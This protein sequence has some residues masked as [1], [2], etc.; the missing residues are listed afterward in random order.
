MGPVKRT[1]TE[2][3]AKGILEQLKIMNLEDEK[4]Y[5]LYGFQIS[6]SESDPAA[7]ITYLEDAIGMTPAYMDYT[8]SVFNYGSWDGAFFMPRPCMV[9]YDGTVDYY[10]NVNDFTKKE[11]GTA[12]DISDA[13]Y[14]GNAMIEWGRNGKK[15]WY[16]ADAANN[17]VYICDK[18]LDEDFHAWS[19]INS[20]GDYVD[21]FYTP[22]F[23][24][25]L[26]ANNKMRSLSGK[27]LSKSLTAYKEI[28]YCEN[29][30]PSTD[31]LWYIDVFA[32]RILINILL[33][34]ISKS[35]NHQAAFGRGLDSGSQAA[36]EAYVTGALNDKGMFFGYNDGNHGVKVFGMENWYSCQFRRTAGLILS[37]GAIKYKMTYGTQD[38]STTI[39]YNDSGTGYIDAAQSLSAGGYIS[40]M[41]LTDKG[42]WVPTAAS[43]GSTTYYCDYL[44]VNTSGNRYALYGGSSSHGA[45]AGSFSCGLDVTAS[46]AAWSYGCALSLKPLA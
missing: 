20:A 3:T 14:G 34:L 36:M 32:D 8:N 18:Q 1:L 13:S 35:T 5:V 10:L 15:I 37:N 28:E 33:T 31:K 43:G 44:W 23:N 9:K 46:G 30:N 24:G 26:D 40:A 19:F 42:A 16:K 2:E 4:D 7:R 17:R 6:E 29:N 11:D 25:S 38:G 39:G 12:S 41:K 21:H 45:R 27:Y 22:I